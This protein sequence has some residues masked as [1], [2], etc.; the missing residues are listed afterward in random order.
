[1]DILK[2]YWHI[3]LALSSILIW[4][5]RLESKVYSNTKKHEELKG[6]PL[7]ITA[8][9]VQ[10]EENRE[11]LE[12]VKKCHNDTFR[13]FALKLTMVAEGISRIEGYIEGR[14]QNDKQR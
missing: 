8:L 10:V 13:D 9:K 4:F 5:A 1:M 3:L 6:A 7:E 2:A 11:D 12:E 14:R